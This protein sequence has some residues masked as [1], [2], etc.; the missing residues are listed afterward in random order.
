MVIKMVG[1]G[2]KEYSR[3]R[4]NLFDA[5]IVCL[6]MIDLLVFA[7]FG[8]NSGGA[9][10]AFRAIRVL[11]IFKLSRKWKAFNLILSKITASLKDIITFMVLM[12]IFIIVFIIL[13]M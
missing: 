4:F 7:I 8:E 12:N 13:G 6:S 11:R 9:L 1:L 3:D 10:T 2:L 5:L